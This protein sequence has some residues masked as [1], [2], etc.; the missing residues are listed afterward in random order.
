L[1]SYDSQDERKKRIDDMK[2]TTAKSVLAASAL[3]W[4]TLS[5][6]SHAI[7]GI[8][9]EG[10]RGDGADMGRLGVQWDWNKRWFQG[11]NW[12][13]GGYWD[14]AV[15]YWKR[16]SPPGFNEEITDIGFTPVFRLQQNDLRGPYLEAAIGFH[17]LS[18]TSLG[19]KRFST[20]FQFG[21]H[22]GAGVRFG[23]KG[24]YDLGY[25]FQHLSNADIKKPNNG[26]EFHQIRFQYH[27]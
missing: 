25:R 14:L 8:A 13:V 16:S 19:D 20:R 27:F 4:V 26:I 15:G 23:P 9:V 21:D 2:R 6:P 7:D 11:Q 5:A 3:W 10:G 17:L 1:T 22:V 12:H 18:K 24:Q